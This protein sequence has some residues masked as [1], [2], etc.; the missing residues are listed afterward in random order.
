MIKDN[1]RQLG[2]AVKDLTIEVKDVVATLQLEI[3][4]LATT[5]KVMMMALGNNSQEG[6]ASEQHGKG[7]VPN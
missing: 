5:I 4:K 6:S 1:Q 3:S 2:N 7:K